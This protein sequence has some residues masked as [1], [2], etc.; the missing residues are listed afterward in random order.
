MNYTLNTQIKYP[1]EG[2]LKLMLWA[3]DCV[4]NS[5]TD[6]ERLPGYD[7]Y[8]CL[9][10]TEGIQ[11]NAEFLSK[12]EKP[13]YICC[14]NTSSPEQMSEFIKDYMGRFSLIDSDY[15]GN[16]PRMLPEYYAC[17]LSSDGRAYNIEGI[18]GLI[19]YRADYMNALETFGPILDN[20]LNDQ[21]RYIKPMLDLAK[22]NKLEVDMAWTSP[23]LKDHYYDTIRL[24][25][26]N[27]SNR[28][29]SL[30]PKHDIA[31]MID[32]EKLEEYWSQLSDEL[33]AFNKARAEY[34]A[35]VSLEELFSAS[36]WE[37]FTKFLTQKVERLVQ[38]IS[39]F[40]EYTEYDFT[41]V[42]RVLKLSIV[43]R[44]FTGFT[45]NYGFYTDLRKEGHPR[46]YGLWISKEKNTAV[47]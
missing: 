8:L 5:I 42:Q 35:G 1:I 11:E 41:R 16:T 24:G 9:G 4:H 38:D 14:I 18:N 20:N 36:R 15:H 13:G 12:R 19:M 46:T 22:D 27:F 25:Q 28:V 45:V 34:E 39:E 30:N 26:N 37:R 23:D 10:F 32:E 43:A 17:L 31:R 21:R 44:A 33:M 3:G 6:V 40:K 29:K 7:I 47:E 2:P